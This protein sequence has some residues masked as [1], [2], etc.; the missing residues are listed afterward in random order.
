MEMWMAMLMDLQMDIHTRMEMVG[1]LQ[2][3]CFFEYNVLGF[4][5]FLG[6]LECL[7]IPY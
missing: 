3:E 5:Y 7:I 6:L 1:P 2:P 4:S